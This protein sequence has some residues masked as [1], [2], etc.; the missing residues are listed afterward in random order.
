MAA[1]LSF[2][3]SIFGFSVVAGEGLVDETEAY[4]GAGV[5]DKVGAGATGAAGATGVVV[6]TGTVVTGGLDY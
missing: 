2:L 3:R 1:S 5:A 4:F 6:R